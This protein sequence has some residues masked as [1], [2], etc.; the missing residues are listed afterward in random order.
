MDHATV[1][2]GTFKLPSLVHH[3]IPPKPDPEPIETIVPYPEWMMRKFTRVLPGTGVI[4]LVGPPGTGK[5]TA[6][7]QASTIPVHEYVLNKSLERGDIQQ[8]ISHLQ[9]TLEGKCVWVLNP[10]SLLNEQLVREMAKRTWLTRVVLVSN[11]KIWGLDDRLVTYHNIDNFTREVA[12]RIGAT[13]DQLQGCCGDLGQL[14]LSK[15]MSES[16][17]GGRPDKEGHPYFDTWPF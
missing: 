15:F 6:I 5:R 1:G 7:K 2:E 12:T 17:M 3:E 13:N 9:P 11:K 4:G 16:W 8:L 14:Q 10:A